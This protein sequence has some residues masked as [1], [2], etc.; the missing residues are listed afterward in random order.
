MFEIKNERHVDCERTNISCVD[1]S[2]SL[3]LQITNRE[4]STKSA[5]PHLPHELSSQHDNFGCLFERLR[6]S[7]VPN[8]FMCELGAGHHFD[9]MEGSPRHVVPEHLELQ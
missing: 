6:G 8:P 5:D 3:P 9:D 4:I 7:Q 1:I 2:E